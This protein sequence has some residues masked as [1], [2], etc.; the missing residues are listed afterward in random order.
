MNIFKEETTLDK[1]MKKYNIDAI[2]DVDPIFLEQ[3]LKSLTLED[4]INIIKEE[5]IFNIGY[6]ENLNKERIYSYSI[7]KLINS[8]DSL[9]HDLNKLDKSIDYACSIIENFKIFYS[10]V[11]DENFIKRP[12][13]KDNVNCPQIIGYADKKQIKDF[14]ISKINKIEE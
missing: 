9:K 4:S 1:I 7:S 3:I 11:S 2:E 12:E 8:F 6:L 14:I 5:D 10:S 13:F